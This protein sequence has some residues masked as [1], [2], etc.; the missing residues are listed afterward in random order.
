MISTS[1]AV[2]NNPIE[3]RLAEKRVSFYNLSWQSYEQIIAAL[4]NNRAARLTYY[5]GTLEI[6]SALEEHE[7]ANSLIGQLIELLAVELN[8]NLK[9]MGSTTLNKPEL[10]V[11]AKPDKCY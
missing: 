6:V 7:S 5:K 11:G 9:S 1:E 3:T 10:K 2:S 8:L 4:G